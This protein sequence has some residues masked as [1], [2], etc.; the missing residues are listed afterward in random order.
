MAKTKSENKPKK[1]TKSI[2]KVK[3]TSKGLGDTVE[4]VFKATGV[5][6]VAKWVLGEDCGCEER[7]ETLNKLFPYRQPKC[8]LEEEYNYLDNYFTERRNQVNAEIQRELVKINN[9]VF[10]ENF[11]ATSCSSCFLNSIHNKLEKIYNK[12]KDEK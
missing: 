9:R 5:D 7:K 11:R 6:R 2:K 4:K 3:K 12:Y 1:N 8:L 10:S